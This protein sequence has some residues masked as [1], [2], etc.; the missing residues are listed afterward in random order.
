[1][2]TLWMFLALIVHELAVS[3]YATCVGILWQQAMFQNIDT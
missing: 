2:T 3:L 1:M